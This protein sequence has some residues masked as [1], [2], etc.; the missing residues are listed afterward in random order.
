MMSCRSA[1]LLK[2]K[3]TPGSGFCFIHRLVF[4]SQSVFTERHRWYHAQSDVLTEEVRMLPQSQGRALRGLRQNSIT[5]RAIHQ[6]IG[7]QSAS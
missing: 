1:R 6:L 5:V 3:K 4:T 2:M 7:T